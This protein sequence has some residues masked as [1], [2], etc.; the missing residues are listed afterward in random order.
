MHIDVQ[1]DS[2]PAHRSSYT[3]DELK[4]NTYTQLLG[5]LE[6]SSWGQKAGKEIVESQAEIANNPDT[7]SETDPFFKEVYDY[8]WLAGVLP[9]LLPDDN[10]VPTPVHMGLVKFTYYT[11]NNSL[12]H[13]VRGKEFTHDHQDAT[14]YHNGKTISWNVYWGLE[15]GVNYTINYIEQEAK[16][17]IA[18]RVRFVVWLSGL[19][20]IIAGV[21]LV[22]QGY[23]R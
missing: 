7:W 15:E 17:I 3:L 9:K 13:L 14:L 23:V 21:V 11:A 8:A 16:N 22:L 4:G 1:D 2:A 10:A 5:I 6:H 19:S 12:P 18:M 20:S